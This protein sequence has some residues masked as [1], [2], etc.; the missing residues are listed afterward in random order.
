[1]ESNSEIVSTVVW[2]LLWI[3]APFVGIILLWNLLL[4]PMWKVWASHKD[5]QAD[6]QRARNE[7]QIQVAEAQGRVDAAQLNK[8]AAIIEAQAVAAQIEAIGN[9]LTRHDLYLKWQWI[10]MMEETDNTTI[11]VPTEAQI[12]VMEAMR[13]KDSV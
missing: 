7:Q 2:V 3:G 1:M 11:Y 5:G 4:G 6:L 13:L 10:K 12:P 9:Q 8:Q